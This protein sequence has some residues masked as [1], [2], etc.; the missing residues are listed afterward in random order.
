MGDP[1]RV[2][3]ES[4]SWPTTDN[5]EEASA[6]V[7][8]S[9]DYS[10]TASFWLILLIDS[11]QGKADDALPTVAPH[12]AIA[13]FQ[14]FRL[15]VVNTR[16]NKSRGMDENDRSCDENIRKRDIKWVLE[17]SMEKG[18]VVF[19]NRTCPQR[20]SQLPDGGIKDKVVLWVDFVNISNFYFL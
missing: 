11:V 15:S 12:A 17:S 10:L 7:V 6:C 9:S 16:S 1:C 20:I 13:G 19:L 14:P 2:A 18:V 4:K 3:K 8:N 5:E